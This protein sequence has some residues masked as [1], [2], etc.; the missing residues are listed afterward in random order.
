MGKHGKNPQRWTT[1][2]GLA[3]VFLAICAV[4]ALIV[5]DPGK[6]G[7]VCR[8]TSQRITIEI[9]GPDCVPVMHTVTN[10]TDDGHVWVSAR[11]SHGDQFS[12]LQKGPDIV[13]VYE[14]GNKPF[15]GI[16]SD[17]FIMRKWVAVAPSPTPAP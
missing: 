13:R 1:V 6:P 16:I 5:I 10:D 7:P 14:A 11:E 2:L 9:T 8:Y 17:F 3:S 12:Q 4:V 15:A